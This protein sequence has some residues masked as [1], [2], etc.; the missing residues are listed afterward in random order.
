MNLSVFSPI[1][2]PACRV[3]PGTLPPPILT[4]EPGSFAQ[5]TLRRRIPAILREAIDLNPGFAL[6][7][8][9][10]LDELAGELDGGRIRG[11]REDAPDVA[12]WNA[13]SAPYFGRSWLDVPWYWAE[14]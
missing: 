14:A 13:V 12:L 11:L 8:R 2:I 7:V 1:V 9:R 4:S 10:G 3:D 6:P 5:D